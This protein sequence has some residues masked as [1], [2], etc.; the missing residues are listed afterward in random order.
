MA[1]IDSG[2]ENSGVPVVGGS[3]VAQGSFTV[4]GV[5]DVDTAT[6]RRHYQQHQSSSHHSKK[7]PLLVPKVTANGAV[8]HARPYNYASIDSVSISTVIMIDI[9][10]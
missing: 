7:A 5:V 9:D 4:D 10:D 3:T 2:G 1:W 6:Q 8:Y